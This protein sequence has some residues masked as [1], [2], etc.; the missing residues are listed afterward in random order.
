M[1]VSCSGFVPFLWSR[2]LCVSKRLTVLVMLSV[3]PG[4]VLLAFIVLCPLVLKSRVVV[5]FFFVLVCPLSIFRLMML[6]VLCCVSSFFK[7]NCFVLSPCMR[8]IVTLQGTSFLIKFPL[9][10][11][12][13]C[14]LSYVAIST[15]FLIV[16]LTVLDL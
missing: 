3:S 16:H 15:R 13:Q 10:S 4:F 1:P 14:P 5:S 6:V 8:L 7:A 2:M 12:Q 9:G 11:I